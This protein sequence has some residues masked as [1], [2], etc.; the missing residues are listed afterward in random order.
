M[1]KRQQRRRKRENGTG[2]KLKVSF[3]QAIAR[4]W[5]T[6]SDEPCPRLAT[7]LQELGPSP[8]TVEDD[9]IADANCDA[10]D[11][12]EDLK[13]SR[14]CGPRPSS[15][16]SSDPIKPAAKSRLITNIHSSIEKVVA[17]SKGDEY[18]LTTVTA[19]SDLVKC[20]K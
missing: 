18:V 7:L 1:G 8:V 16:S 19:L 4:R 11:Q 14:E 9:V 5:S 17:A 20:V 13:D 3:K 12:Q 10:E 2:D 6:D 15:S